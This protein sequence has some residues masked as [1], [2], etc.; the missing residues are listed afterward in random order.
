M[1]QFLDYIASVF[2]PNKVE[3]K[4]N[5]SN[6]HVT[7]SENS[8]TQAFGRG[9]S[10]KNVTKFGEISKSNKK[11][12]YIYQAIGAFAFL[13]H[14][15]MVALPKIQHDTF[16]LLEPDGWQLVTLSFIPLVVHLASIDAMNKINKPLQDGV[17]LTSKN[18]GLDLNNN[19]F[20]QSLK[21]VILLMAL[22]QLSSVVLDKL[23]WG[24]IMIVSLF[25]CNFNKSTN[26]HP[27]N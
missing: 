9:E 7:F 14:L 1:G 24:V 21:I 23:L 25:Q 4:D 18:L 5:K 15:S 20:S 13:V 6:N 19:D 10:D 17:K 3:S 16:D 26:V 8:F 2:N 27:T 12:I 11:T 22:C